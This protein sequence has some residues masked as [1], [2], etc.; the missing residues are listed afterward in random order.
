MAKSLRNFQKPFDGT[1]LEKPFVP[2]A[3]I[4]FQKVLKIE[5]PIEHQKGL[6]MA[7]P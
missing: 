7:R 3:K 2:N 6:A 5:Q 4:Q 1:N